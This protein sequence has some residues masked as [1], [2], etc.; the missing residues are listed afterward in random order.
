MDD[1]YEWARLNL[2][3]ITERS[4]LD[5]FLATA[6]MAGTEF[7]AGKI[8]INISVILLLSCN[9]LKLNHINTYK[10]FNKFV[11]EYSIYLYIYNLSLYV[12]LLYIL[13]KDKMYTLCNPISANHY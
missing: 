6:E 1:G 10:M 12:E 11:M 5:D 7:I 4:T 8:I 9:K 13:Q 2:Q 3:S